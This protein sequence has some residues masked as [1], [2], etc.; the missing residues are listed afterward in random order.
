MVLNM[1]ELSIL[2]I[3]LTHKY[4][5]IIAE[6]QQLLKEFSFTKIGRNAIKFLL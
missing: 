5:L 4:G 1:S 6:P 2:T 3:E